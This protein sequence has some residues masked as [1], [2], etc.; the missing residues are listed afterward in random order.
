MPEPD[1]EGLLTRVICDPI[2]CG[3]MRDQVTFTT[4]TN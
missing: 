3:V 1:Q 2:P 4:N